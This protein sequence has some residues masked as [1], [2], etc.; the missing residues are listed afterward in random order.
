MHLLSCS[1]EKKREKK[2]V[3][4][5][6]KFLRHGC[7][8]CFDFLLFGEFHP[9]IIHLSSVRYPSIKPQSADS[10]LNAAALKF[11]RCGIFHPLH[12]KEK[13]GGCEKTSGFQA[14][15]RQV[16]GGFQAGSWES[17][18]ASVEPPQ[19]HHHH[20]HLSLQLCSAFLISTVTQHHSG[21]RTVNRKVS[22]MSFF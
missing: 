14:G 15:S 17:H 11:Q 20:H 2:R 3:K 4:K 18:L 7:R 12:Q 6:E 5:A 16:P 19:Q 21:A 1:P 10:A 8:L 22:V 9:S 13:I